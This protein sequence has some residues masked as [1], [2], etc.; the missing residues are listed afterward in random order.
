MD[1]TQLLLTIVLSLSTCLLVVIGIQLIF[2]LR[3]FRAI[4]NRINKIIEGFESLGTGL[5][6]GLSEIAGF[7]NGFKALTKII[8]IVS[9]KKNEEPT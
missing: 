3:E 4:L 1:S 9:P 5:D 7:M 2:I 8:N 6:H